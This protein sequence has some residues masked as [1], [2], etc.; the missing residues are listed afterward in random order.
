MSAQDWTDGHAE[1]AQITLWC[2]R[3]LTAP[4]AE[5]VVIE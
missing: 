3:A 1:C 2:E 5:L 4:G